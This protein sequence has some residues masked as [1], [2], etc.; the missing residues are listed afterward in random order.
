MIRGP[1]RR[2]DEDQPP[3]LGSWGKMYTLVLV[4]L[5]VLI[6]LLALLGWWYR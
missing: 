6:G 2:T 5:I 4:V 1:A 3:F